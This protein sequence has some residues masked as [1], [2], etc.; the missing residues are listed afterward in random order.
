MAILNDIRKHGIFLIIIIALA[1]FA[2]VLSGVIGNGNN[3]PKGETVVATVNGVDLPRE[4][5]MRKVETRQRN[6][7]GNVA[8]NQ[9]MNVVWQQELRRV[10]LEEQYEALGLTAEKAQINDAISNALANNT[11]FQNELGLFSEA[12]MQEYIASIKATA[13]AGNPSAYLA[14]LDFEESI[15]NSVLETNYFN[16]VKGGLITTLSEGEQ[17]YHFQNDNIN[18]EFVQVPYAKIADE[19]ITVSDAEIEA[20][21]RTH[22]KDYEVE[23]QVDIQYISFSEDPSSED[24]DAA[25]TEISGLVNDFAAATNIEEFVNANSEIAHIDRWFLKNNLPENIADTLMGMNLNDVYGPY[26]EGNSY[27]L[28]KVYET[29]QM[30]DSAKARHILIR[31][32]GLSTAPQDVVRT[33]E[34]ARKL[35]DS[36]LSVVKRDAS[37]F[38]ALATEFSEDLSNKDKGGDLGYFTP[39]RMVQPFNDFIFDNEIGDKD[40]VETSFGFHVIAIDDQKNIQKAIKVAVILKQIQASEKTINEVFSKATKFEIAVEKGDFTEL[41]KEAGL[42]PSPVN[43]IGELDANIPGIGENRSIVSWAFNEE[44][45]IGDVKRVN[46]NN[47]YVIAQLTRRNPKGLLSVAE[48]SVTVTPILRNEKK[49]KKIRESISSTDINE[50]ASSQN[51]TVKTASAINMANPTIAG[52][53]T[54]PKVIG[55]AFGL[56]VGETS[57]LIDGEKGVYMVRVTAVNNAVDVQDYSTFANQLNNKTAPSINGNAFNALKNA[58][59]IEDNRADFY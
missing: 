57:G 42:T 11:T 56:K 19:D 25:K 26:K 33:K 46:I 39:G 38:D 55:A 4:E 59:T 54:E 5:F 12:K 30:A 35:A 2:F 27:S 48:S 23:P 52:A 34:D 53:G 14:W 24:V 47:G 1:L 51:V 36:I 10:L 44:T 13:D 32:E 49:A 9:A 20:Y 40:V 7:G 21:V 37:K 43:K 29:R 18:I 17:D 41:A 28:A 15:I 6:L 58:A 50:V 31:F 3:S 8:T 22:S 45:N 16:L